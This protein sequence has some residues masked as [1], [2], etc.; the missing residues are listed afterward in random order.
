M[1]PPPPSAA[2][3]PTSHRTVRYFPHF[4][5]YRSLK[6]LIFLLCLITKVITPNHD[7]TH[8]PNKLVDIYT[9]NRTLDLSPIPFGT[10]GAS[11]LFPEIPLPGF[12]TATCKDQ[13]C[14]FEPAA[15]RSLT[16]QSRQ[17]LWRRGRAGIA[18]LGRG[19]GEWYKESALAGV[20]FFS[21]KD[22][23]PPPDE[24]GLL[25]P[26]SAAAARNLISTCELA[27]AAYWT[28]RGKHPISSRGPW[29]HRLSVWL[30]DGLHQIPCPYL[31]Y[32]FIGIVLRDLIVFLVGSG[33][34]AT[35]GLVSLLVLAC[36][37]YLPPYSTFSRAFSRAARWIPF[38]HLIPRLRALLFTS[39]EFV[40]FS[41]VYLFL[42]ADSLFTML[43]GIPPV[44]SDIPLSWF[45]HRHYSRYSSP[46]PVLLCGALSWLVFLATWHISAPIYRLLLSATVALAK[47]AYLL[48]QVVRRVR[49]YRY[50]YVR[51]S[52]MLGP[53]LS[54]LARQALVDVT[55]LLLYF[56]AG[57]WISNVFWEAVVPN[58]L[59]YSPTVG[60]LAGYLGIRY[61][62]GG[63]YA[64]GRWVFRGLGRSE[65]VR[66]SATPLRGEL[67]EGWIGGDPVGESEDNI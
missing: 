41:A 46:L 37:R 33:Y 12:P 65:V 35:L 3:D 5:P 25:D 67:I 62:L 11:I 66:V 55:T 61:A 63:R 24:F 15:D 10:I 53:Y 13:K 58:W 20:F 18:G 51:S 36:R 52:R 14:R 50:A 47:H 27:R 56:E 19:I 45:G 23:S 39:C 43:L 60:I 40:L 28:Y 44:L 29:T 38:L 26:S 17:E 1:P 31:D 42:S 6:N 34:I 8:Y 16:E 48:R 57:T 4:T 64:S 22:S 21:H 7:L 49:Y 54:Y 30:N 9:S 2:I 32:V 59:K